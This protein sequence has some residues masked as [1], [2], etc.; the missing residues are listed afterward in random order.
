VVLVDEVLV[1][2]DVD[3]A[4]EVPVPLIE[5]EDVELEVV[6]VVW[7][8]EAVGNVTICVDS[9]VLPLEVRVLVI[10][11]EDSVKVVVSETDWV[12]V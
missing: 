10:V 6:L 4:D 11:P 2:V 1:I 8:R 7:L 5:P 3:E 9:E 12:R